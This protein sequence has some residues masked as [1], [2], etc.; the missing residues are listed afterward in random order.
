MGRIGGGLT[1]LAAGVAGLVGCA[2]AGVGEQD[3][4]AIAC[5]AIDSVVGGGSAAGR[6]TV[7]G[8]ERIRDVTDP[9]PET[10]RWL[11]A[12]ITLLQTADPDQ[13]PAEARALLVDG[14]ADHGHALRNLPA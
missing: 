9:A 8:L 14:C 1:V 4:Y 11:D 3:A 10:R 2:E 12:A 6:A 5:P 13:L 7:A